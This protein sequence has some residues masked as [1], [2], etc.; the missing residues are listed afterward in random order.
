MQYNTSRI[1]KNFGCK[2]RD[3]PGFNLKL[4]G[5]PIDGGEA[6]DNTNNHDNDDKQGLKDNDVVNT[7]SYLV[8]KSKILVIWVFGR[9]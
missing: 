2:I 9:R 4:N 7:L 5:N 1:L 3:Q 6:D 8:I